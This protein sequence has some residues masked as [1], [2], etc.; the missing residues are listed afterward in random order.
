MAGVGAR[1]VRVVP[2]CGGVGGPSAEHRDLVV[3]VEEFGGGGPGV[4]DPDD[5]ASGAS[6]E[7]GGCV[8]ERP[9]QPFRF[10][11]CELA[12]AA[13]LLEPADEIVGEAHDL[14]PGAVRVEVGEREPF[15]AGVLQR[16]DVVFD[17]GV[18]AYVRVQRDGVA[19]GV[20][21]VTPIPVAI[22]RGTAIVGRL[23]GGAR[24]AR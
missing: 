6:H 24:D 23:G 12:G 22:G 16:F 4:D 20:G 19:D 5:V 10:G 15:E 2:A 11:A 17:V 13:E 7:P 14:H 3:G 1:G 21:V 8:P 9:T 18:V